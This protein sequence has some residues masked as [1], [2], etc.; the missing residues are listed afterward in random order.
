MY[1]SVGEGDV[2]PEHGDLIH[3]HPPMH[4]RQSQYCYKGVETL[5][6]AD[7]TSLPVLILSIIVVLRSLIG[8]AAAPLDGE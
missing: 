5:A 8:H 1:V 4:A 6:A 3:T 7:T 2:P